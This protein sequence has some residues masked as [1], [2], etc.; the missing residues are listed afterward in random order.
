MF[1]WKLSIDIIPNHKAKNF[2]NFFD[3]TW[4]NINVQWLEQQPKAAETLHYLRT[5]YSLLDS[6]TVRIE[7]LLKVMNDL[8]YSV[9]DFLRLHH[10]KM[11]KLPVSERQKMLKVIKKLDQLLFK[12]EKILEN[13]RVQITAN[14]KLYTEFL[15]YYQYSDGVN[16]AR[17]YR[18]LDLI[19]DPTG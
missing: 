7:L 2:Y 4:N 16:Y 3:P 8:K 17:D 9:I 19:S 11:V 1:F 12:F 15:Q 14:K 5:P 13:E 10:H 6:V 18:Y